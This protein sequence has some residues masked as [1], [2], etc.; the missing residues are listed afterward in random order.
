MTEYFTLSSM[1]A[2]RVVFFGA[3]A[4]GAAILIDSALSPHVVFE[5]ERA[6]S[7]AIGIALLMP[8]IMAIARPPVAAKRRAVH[9]TVVT[10]LWL[11]ATATMLGALIC[12]VGALVN[13]TGGPAP[14][15]MTSTGRYTVAVREYGG[16]TPETDFVEVYQVCQIAPGLVLSKLI[17][18]RTGYYDGT[19]RVLD[20]AHVQLEAETLALLPLAWPLC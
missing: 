2:R 6:N 4:C 12:F 19:V 11:C 5:D 16:V 8:L 20:Q 17:D 1:S 13:F 9:I 18:S 15:Q 14:D 3:L 7:V 10:V